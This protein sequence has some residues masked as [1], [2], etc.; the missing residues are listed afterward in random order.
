MATKKYVSLEKLS[1]YDEKIKKVIA[2]SDTATLDSAKAYADGLAKNYDEAG[3]A[4]AVQGKLDEE[5]TRAKAREDE[6][7]GLVATAQKDVDDL[8]KYVGTIPATATATDV[9]GYVQEKTAGIATDA[10]LSELS[11]KVDGLQTTV[12]EIAKDYL[13]SEDETALTDLITAEANRAKGI[14]GGLET[15]LAAVEGDYLKKTDKE[16]LQAGIDGITK[17]YLKAADKKE[18]SDAI[19][20][21]ADRAKEVEEGLQTQIN[22]IMNNPDTEGVINSINEFTQYITDHG[23]I[24]EGFRTDIDANTKAIEDHEA[25]AAQ[26]YETKTDADAKYAELAAKAVQ[27]DWSVNDSEDP[28][29]IQNRPFYEVEGD[30]EVIFDR[31]IPV[32]DYTYNDYVDEYNTGYVYR[33]DVME[34]PF[35]VTENTTFTVILDGVTYTNVPWSMDYYLC[36]GD[37]DMVNYPFRIYNDARTYFLYEGGNY[38]INVKGTAPSHVKIIVGDAGEIVQLDEKFIPDT[39]ARVSEVDAVETRLDAIEAQLGGGE[40][41][42]TEQIGTAVDT[43]KTEVLEELTTTAEDIRIAF[44]NS[45]AVVLAE[46]QKGIDAVQA[47]L[48]IHEEDAVA[49]ITT[50]E[51]TTWNNALQASDITVGAANG[52]IAVKGTD[53]A[54]KGLG[55]AAYVATTAFDAAGSAAQA[56]TDAKAYTDTEF[57]K[58]IECGEDDINAL[59]A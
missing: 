22:T 2:D 16:A 26:T 13:T 52:T 51:R 55:S 58:F 29:Y 30:G 31:T 7:A 10:A 15:R 40:G 50:P 6:I 33:G 48:D 35:D 43:A 37:K 44:A 8:E 38:S 25:L 9:I 36:I 42:V 3:A 54:V 1:L 24:A 34:D 28:A 56:L 18:L 4:A 45:D 11:G 57:A 49:H 23:E 12:Q 47:A 27:G 5:V 53:V 46:A 32:E 39:I 14:E 59:F 20:A 41:S 17:D 21:E 19:T